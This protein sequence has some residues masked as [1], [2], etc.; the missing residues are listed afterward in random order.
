MLLR[1]LVSVLLQHF[2]HLAVWLW[3]PCATPIMQSVLVSVENWAA[4]LWRNMNPG[5]FYL[6][7]ADLKVLSW[8]F[9]KSTCLQ[10]LPLGLFCWE[11]YVSY[12]YRL[13]FS[14]LI[15]EFW[16][17]FSLDVTSVFLPILGFLWCMCWWVW[18]YFS[19]PFWIPSCFFIPFWF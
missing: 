19:S 3:F 15:L 14:H 4:N 2:T 12:I 9:N 5:H 17:I 13:I 10:R 6:F 18:W 11:F 16:A 7:L 1:F 8:A